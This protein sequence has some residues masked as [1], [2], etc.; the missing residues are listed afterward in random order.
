MSI[1]EMEEM[2]GIKHAQKYECPF[3]NCDD[4]CSKNLTPEDC[5]EQY[6]QYLIELVCKMGNS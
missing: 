6:E 5:E 2:L 4:D 1:K 3:G